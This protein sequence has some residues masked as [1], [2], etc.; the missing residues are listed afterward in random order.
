MN[1]TVCVA[2]YM[3][4]LAL[5]IREITTECRVPIVKKPATRPRPV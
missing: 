1:A 5:K 3:D 4:M 2:K